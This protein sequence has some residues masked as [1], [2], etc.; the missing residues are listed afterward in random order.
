MG[1]ATGIRTRKKHPDK[2]LSVLGIR[3][4]EKPGRYADGN[5]LYLKVD[6]SGAKRWELRT[7]VRGKRCDIGLGG[8]KAVSLAEARE[9]AR[10]YRAM[11]R[12][13]EDPLAEKR[14]ARKVVP[15]FRV[16]A[17]TVH[18]EHAKAWKNAKHADQWINTLKTY[19]YPALGDRRVDQ[20][21]TPEILKALSPIWLTKQET[22]RRVRQRIGTVLDWAKAAGFR[23][24]NNPVEE[25]SKAL[26]RQSDRKGH[27]AALPYVE[28]PTFVQHL[29]GED[30]TIPDLA[31]EFLILTAARTGE[32]LE[33]K[34]DEIDL[35]QA[36]WTI[37]A[38][39]MKAGREHRVPLAPRC[40]ELLN[41]VKLFAAGS[42][43]VFP[44][45]SGKKP[46]SNMA[47][48]MS[49]RRMNSAYT[50]HGFRSA[51]RD[52]ASE[53]TNFAR[54]ICEAALAHIVKDKTEAAY[55][56]GDLFEKRR[57]LMATWAAFVGGHVAS[58]T[59]LR[60][61]G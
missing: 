12:N 47:L 19:A 30:A 18:E 10:K 48:L 58:I 29:R 37:P 15:T 28:V 32:V 16:A 11:A 25:I 56:R 27:H 1:G 2:A 41:Q 33:A 4:I 20:I 49:M 55:R 54:E 5:G 23:S 9:Q 50:V 44:G 35:E 45:R 13:D 51:F 36:A 24:G 34:W 61:L 7:V 46:M 38:A 40:I 17:E 6:V 42:G 21:D 43:F 22:A 14:R 39:R 52:W 59:T 57:E 3:A 8:L 53:R 26:P 31:F 60:S